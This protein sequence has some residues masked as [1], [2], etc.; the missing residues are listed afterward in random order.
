MLRTFPLNNCV[1]RLNVASKNQWD[2]L[3]NLSALYRG[4]L[5]SCQRLYGL[6]A[7]FL[8]N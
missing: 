1:Y 2:L 3:I 8:R 7:L 6:D 4:G 5:I